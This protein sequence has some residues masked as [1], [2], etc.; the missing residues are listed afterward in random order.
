MRGNIGG[1]EAPGGICGVGPVDGTAVGALALWFCIELSAAMGAAACTEAA[2]GL[3]LDG[4]D[5][6]CWDDC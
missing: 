3:A 6:C 4:A 1:I 5:G 2:A